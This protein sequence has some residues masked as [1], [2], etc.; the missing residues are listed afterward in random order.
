[1]K[2]VL[3]LLFCAVAYAAISN[4]CV[5]ELKTR[6]KGTVLTESDAQYVEET[7]TYNPRYNTKPGAVVLPRDEEDVIAAL[8]VAQTHNVAIRAFS[9]GHSYEG[10]GLC[11]G[12]VISFRSA[13]WRQ[14]SVAQNL[15][16][17][18]A[19]AQLIDAH[20]AT[21]PLNMGVVAGLCPSVGIVPFTLGGG[22]GSLSRK[23]GL[24]A[25]N[26]VSFRLIL[27][28][29]T[30]L[31]VSAEK[32]TDLFWALR[33]GAGGNFGIVTEM[34]VKSHPIDQDM[35][36]GEIC[37]DWAENGREVFQWWASQVNSA[38]LP[39]E[40]TLNAR[41]HYGP[42]DQKGSDGK[43]QFCMQ[44][45]YAGK[46]KDAEPVVSP[47]LRSLPTAVSDS[48]GVQS[49]LSETE[50]EH[51][52]VSKLYGLHVYTRSGYFETMPEE[53]V[54]I[55]ADAVESAP[56]I[57]NCIIDFDHLHGA[58]SRVKTNDT[59]YFNRGARYN[60]QIIANWE[61]GDPRG[62][63]YVQWASS[64]YDRVRPFISGHYVNYIDSEVV[65][66]QQEYYGGNY[67]R[68]VDIKSAVD[69][70]NVFNGPQSIG[71]QW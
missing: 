31:T 19:G 29:G 27:A 45:F 28:N 8:A 15:V 55:L 33:G 43:Q 44:P 68:L 11:D 59:P 51:E 63:E 13:L 62:D 34:T 21:I 32:N 56:T 2:L 70:S 66:W 58:I 35:F 38:A 12:I 14:V 16:T 71:S 65:N 25:D 42:L 46:A 22:Y 48:T 3:A 4:E 50:H 26:V 67:D 52:K 30:A 5:S 41:S 17:V 9:G 18:R 1:M 60:L 6:I 10:Y 49:W 54:N 36:M 69:P 7:K 40:L 24:S 61:Q 53:L 64:L 47:L 39:N 57:G 23:V 20:R 37:F